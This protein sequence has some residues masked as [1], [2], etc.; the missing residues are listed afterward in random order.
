M[1]VGNFTFYHQGKLSKHDGDI[2]LGT[3]SIM[4]ILVAAAYTPAVTTD[5]T[6]ADVSANEIADTDYAQQLVTA[7]TSSIDGS[8]VITVD[9]ADVPFGNPVSI[10]AKYAVFAKRAGASL[11]A[12][13]SL[14]G[15][16]DL[17]DTTTAAE[18]SS[19]NSEFSVKTPN[20]F[21]TLT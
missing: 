11:V 17:D 18:V 8:G 12:G 2:D 13:D 15:Y 21:Y 10:T 20:G 5:A 14:L 6:Y 9:S 4:C 7:L 3:D 16:V 19:T 1:A